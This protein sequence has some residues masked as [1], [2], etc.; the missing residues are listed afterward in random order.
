M[1]NATSNTAPAFQLS[2]SQLE[3]LKMVAIA[4]M[5]IDHWDAIIESREYIWLNIIGR[6]AF[7]LFCFIAAYN[8]EYHTRRPLRYIGRL[9]LFGMASQLV[10]MWAVTPE[11]LNILF[12]LAFGLMT[13]WAY[14]HRAVFLQYPQKM[15]YLIYIVLFAIWYALGFNV[16]YYHSGIILVPALVIWLRERSDVVL[17]GIIIATLAANLFYFFAVVGLFS[18]ALVYLVQY[19]KM[20][21]ARM[22]RYF[23]YAFYP[24]H[25]FLLKLLAVYYFAN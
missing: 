5:F 8:Y 22:P 7:P 11:R 25:I 20:P 18:Y 6:L 16:D 13:I 24:L 1:D 14:D 17:V 10:Y 4:T 2:S 12:T 9:F 23:Y 21:V 19:I 3:I 15:R